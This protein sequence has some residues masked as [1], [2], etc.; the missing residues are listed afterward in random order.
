MPRRRLA[1]AAHGGQPR[2]S[3][4][5]AWRRLLPGLGV[6]AAMMGPAFPVPVQDVHRGL[7]GA[8]HILGRQRPFIAYFFPSLPAAQAAPPPT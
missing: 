6:A 1:F 3:M 5:A 4:N 2:A 7:V 8:Q